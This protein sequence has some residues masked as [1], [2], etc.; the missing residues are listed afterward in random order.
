MTVKAHS[1]VS[2]AGFSRTA[3]RLMRHAGAAQWG[4]WPARRPRFDRL[5]GKRFHNRQ[6]PPTTL[7]TGHPPVSIPQRPCAANRPADAPA[8]RQAI[9]SGSSPPQRSGA[10]ARTAAQFYR[11]LS[12]ASRRDSV[13]N[14]GRK[15]ARG[16]MS[17]RAVG[18][19]K[20]LYRCGASG[21][22]APRPG[23][24]PRTSSSEMQIP[25]HG[26]EYP[27]LL[28]EAVIAGERAARGRGVRIHPITLA[29]DYAIEPRRQ[30][31]DDRCERS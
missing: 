16:G 6:R 15:A 9:P 8:L 1:T 17:V 5:T 24:A 10:I 3:A 20:L 19:L 29:H 25:Q 31:L 27:R 18:A 12:C 30:R 26:G 11:P 7:R 4:H 23:G 21:S 2:T 28:R 14:K 22:G 13:R